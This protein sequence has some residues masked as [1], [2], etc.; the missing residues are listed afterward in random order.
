MIK[1][2]SVHLLQTEARGREVNMQYCP[3]FDSGKLFGII[4][5]LIYKFFLLQI[6]LL[7]SAFNE[8]G[9]LMQGI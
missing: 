1:G 9:D 6:I 3:Y 5:M 2:F 4:F 8:Q 7:F